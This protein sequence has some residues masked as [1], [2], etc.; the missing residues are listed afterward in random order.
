MPIAEFTA[1]AT[2]FKTAR[3][4]VGLAFD[5][6]VDAER[7]DA[8][9]QAMNQLLDAQEK[10]FGLREVLDAMQDEIRSLKEAERSR[11]EWSEKANEYVLVQGPG[12]AW[13]QQSKIDPTRYS[14]PV[15]MGKKVLT[16][17]QPRGQYSGRQDCFV[18]EQGF[19]VNLDKPVPPATPRARGGGPNGWMGN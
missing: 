12:G 10:M 11:N 4:M 14:C 18:C 1:A 5:A 3:E 15:C 2:A 19:Q 9:L 16:V 8:R 17:L 7:R 13:V 6:K